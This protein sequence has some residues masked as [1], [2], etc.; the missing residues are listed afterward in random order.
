MVP[1][2]SQDRSACSGAAPDMAARRMEGLRCSARCSLP[3]ACTRPG[4]AALAS[5]FARFGSPNSG[6]T[7]PAHARRWQRLIAL[8]I[9]SA[10]L[11][12]NQTHSP[13]AR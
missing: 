11:A 8:L 5:P 4:A 7:K 2:T 13:R 10:S 1:Q 6:S 12:S 9:L 3:A